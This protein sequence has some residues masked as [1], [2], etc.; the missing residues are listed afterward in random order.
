MKTDYEKKIFVLQKSLYKSLLKGGIIMGKTVQKTGKTIEDAVKEALSELNT[1]EDKVV[2]EVVEEPTKGLLGIGAKAAIVRVTEKEDKKSLVD[3]FLSDI[4]NCLAIDF[5]K[6]FEEKEDSLR[7]NLDGK[8]MGLIIGHKGET[9]D[10]LQLL[11]SVIANKNGE[12]KRIELDVQNYRA[13][14]KETL[15]SL[16]QRKAREVIKYGRS[17]TLEPMTP[18]ERRIIHTALQ[19]DEKVTTESTGLEP[20]RKVVIKKV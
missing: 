7:V 16:A 14:R 20:F 17:I 19:E 13:K 8:D 9:L 2:V 1:T 6:T 11:T 12:Y 15:I 18:Y 10:A 5:T 4:S 3:N